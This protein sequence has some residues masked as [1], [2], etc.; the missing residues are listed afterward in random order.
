[1]KTLRG[2]Q[3]ECITRAL[4][5]FRSDR[6]FLCHA[7]PG[8]GKSIM[9]ARLAKE[10]KQGGFIDYVMIFA[11]SRTVAVNM[12][13]VFAETLRGRFDGKIG[14]IGASFTY[15]GMVGLKR[16]YWDLIRESRVLVVLDEIHH[17]SSAAAGSGN[18]WGDL[19]EAHIQNQASFTLSL[20]G[21]PWRSDKAP[22]ALAQY[23]DPDGQVAC[24]YAYGLFQAV[25]ENVCR[26]PKITLVDNDNV[27]VSKFKDPA[28]SIESYASIEQCMSESDL[29]YDK[30]ILRNEHALQQVLDLA[31]AKLNEIRQ[32]VP[33]AAGLVVA[34]TIEHAHQI[35]DLLHAFGESPMLV[36]SEEPDAQASIQ[37]FKHAKTRWIVSVGMV[38]EG[39]DIPRLQVCCHF[40]RIRTE[41]H[42]RQVLGR[43]LRKR[44]LRDDDAWLFMLAEPTLSGFA[45]RVKDDLPDHEVLFRRHSQRATPNNGNGTVA[46]RDFDPELKVVFG[47]VTSC[48]EIGT[49]SLATNNHNQVINLVGSYHQYLI[50]IFDSPCTQ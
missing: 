43:V 41:L 45:K 14:A 38:S 27:T 31:C 25:S 49:L 44:N 23:S 4:D 21:T 18:T 42:F 8:A 5:H 26:I 33:D 20:S 35:V 12:A 9:A 16:V 17:C 28:H 2:W 34:S 15:Q 46:S 6:H 7:T 1:M 22:V 10:L 13:N 30:A 32:E 19:I 11:P 29:S 36:T 50:R 40:S 48:N 37:L 47:S 39:T 3:L 24:N